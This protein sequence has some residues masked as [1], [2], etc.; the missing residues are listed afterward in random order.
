MLDLTIRTPFPSSQSS[1]PGL[2]SNDTNFFYTYSHSLISLICDIK[3]AHNPF[4][5]KLQI[6]YAHFF[7]FSFA[8][9]LVETSE[10]ELCHMT[11]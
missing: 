6:F 11:A 10:Q 2:Y 3:A 5:I 1:V 4:L 9:N 8:V 7:L